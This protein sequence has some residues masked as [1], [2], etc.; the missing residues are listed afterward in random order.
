MSI[1]TESLEKVD[2]ASERRRGLR[3]RQSRPVKVFDPASARYVGGQTRDVS[4]SGLRL[5]LPVSSPIAPGRLVHVHIGVS[6]GPEGLAQ[7]RGMIPARVVWVDRGE[8]MSMT[9]GVELVARV[10][11]ADAA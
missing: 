1:V 10:A 7:R 6:M 11:A 9:A 4:A 2:D 5:E 8:G 3:I